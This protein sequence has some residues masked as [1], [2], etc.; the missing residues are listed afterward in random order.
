MYLL[1]Q[2]DISLIKFDIAYDS[3][4]GQSCNI[5]SINDQYEYLLPIGLKLTNEGLMSWL[6]SRVI[7]KNRE[8]VDSFLAKNGLSHNDTKGII[9][10]CKGLSLNDSYWIVDENFDG[11]YKD[12]NLYE[13]DF[14]KALSLL[15]YTGY[16]SSKARGFT[17]SPEFTTNGN[18]R[19]GWR[20]LNDV[21]KLFKG[22]T[23]GGANTGFEPYSEFFASQIAEQMGI[24][25][26]SYDLS[27]WKHNLCSTCDLFSD[28]NHSYVPMYRFMEK[29]TLRSTAEFLKGISEECYN[30]YID[31]LIFDSLIYN[32]DRHYGNFGLLVDNNTNKP[33]ALAPLFD[34]GIS[35]FNQGMP[36]DFDN[37][38]VYSKTRL[39]HSGAS[40][41]AIAEEF[42]TNRQKDKL[43]KLIG[44]KFSNH[45]TYPMSM[46]RKKSIEKYIQKR[47]HFLLNLEVKH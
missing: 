33:Y 18:L 24:K 7:P 31:M 16:G 8:F 27:M 12:Y 1:K 37:L 14:V 35:L 44:F 2:Y 30:E 4:E 28:I 38:D 40:F 42:I 43:K 45:K 36:D 15:A 13:N 11:K 5:I 47:V 46:K 10:I 17:S 23:S 39:S 41:D 3:L 19:K 21:V 29:P 6:R 34:H 20:R 32:E 22:G 25:H 9:D 26:V